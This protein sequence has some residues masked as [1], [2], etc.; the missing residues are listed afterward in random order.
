MIT[1]FRRNWF[2]G[3]KNCRNTSEN[4]INNTGLLKND[5]LNSE[6]IFSTNKKGT[7]IPIRSRSCGIPQLQY[8]L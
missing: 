4:R 2:Y 6:K 7:I 1:V 5:F 3:Q 8:S